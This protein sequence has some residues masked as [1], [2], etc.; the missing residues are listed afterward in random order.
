MQHFNVA[1]AGGLL[2][3]ALAGC[4]EKPPIESRLPAGALAWQPYYL[5]Q[6]LRFG[7]ARTSQVR[8]FTIT[9]VRD[10]FIEYSQG[11]NAPVYLGPATKYKTESITVKMSR[12]DTVRYMRTAVSTPTKPDSILFTTG[13]QLLNL[14]AAD[15][16]SGVLSAGVGWDVGFQRSLPLQEVLKGQMPIDTTQQLLPAIRL[17]GVAYGPVLSIA[18]Q[19]SA[20]TGTYDSFP[21]NKPARRIYYAQGFG[22]V[23]FVEGTTLWYRLP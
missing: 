18:N 15:D 13:T 22:V 5:G 2:S 20:P 21:R 7:Q 23:G 9:E 16:L 11:G 17:G 14:L 12:T 10:E 3:V 19:A 1:L 6:V 8:T 4:S